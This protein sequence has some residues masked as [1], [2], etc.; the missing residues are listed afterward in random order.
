MLSYSSAAT[1]ATWQSALLKSANVQTHR[2]SVV[3]SASLIIPRLYL[4]NFLTARDEKQLQALGVTHVVSVLEH[5]PKYSSRVKTLHIALSDTS[6]TNILDH[7]DTT[8]EFIRAALAENEEN[9]V[10]VHCLM[11]ISRSATVVCAYL[12]ATQSMHPTE[13]L[14]YVM[15]RRSIVCPNLGFRKQLEVY[16]MRFV[17]R[18]ASH[19]S[20][21]KGR[22]VNMSEGIAHRIRKLTGGQ[23]SVQVRAVA[24]VGRNGAATRT[25]ASKGEGFHLDLPPQIHSSS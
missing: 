1:N 13:A 10:L 25:K 2:T 5:P 21:V 18:K 23:S 17:G 20:S 8:T 7:L 14:D 6:D 9:K 16:G 3:H 15:E 22:I 11:G 4:S 24:H 19:P 12:I